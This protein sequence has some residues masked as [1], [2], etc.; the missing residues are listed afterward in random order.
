MKKISKS[1]TENIVRKT[2]KISV[3]IDERLVRYL[4]EF[5]KLTKTNRSAMA[6]LFIGQGYS[7]TVLNLKV[8]WNVLLTKG[9]LS[10]EKKDKVKA[11]L[12]ELTEIEAGKLE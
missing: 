3:E 4:D 9:D 2:K 11:V 10:K 5:A 7:P 1:V 6:E 8:S 12:K